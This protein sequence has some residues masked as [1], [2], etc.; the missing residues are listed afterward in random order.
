[1]NRTFPL[2]AAA[3]LFCGTPLLK[4]ADKPNILFIMSDDHTAQAIG[5]YATLLKGLN[6]TPTIDSLAE[7]GILFENAFVTNSIC[8]PS[9]ACIITGQYNHIN[10]VFDLGGNIPPEKQMLPIEMKKAGY[11]TAVIGKWHLKREPNFDYYKVLPGQGKYFDTEL[12]IQGEKP[13]PGNVEV[14]EGKHSSDVITDAALDWLRNERDPDKPFFLCHQYKAPHDYF[15]NAPRYQSYLADVEIPEPQTLYDVPDT[16]GSIGTRGHEDELTPHIG[17][18]IGSRNPRRS[19]AT[20]LFA[21][22]PEEYPEDYDPEKLS[23]VETTAISYQAYLKKYLRCVKGVDDNLK[24]LFDYLKEEG[25]YDKTLIIYTGDQGF[26]LGEKDFQDKRWAYDE[27]QRMPLIIRYPQAI[28]AGIRTDAIIENVDF[29]A[30]MLDY[31]GAAIPEGIQGKSFR[32]ICETGREPAN[33]KDAAYYRYWMH[34]AHH[35]NPGEMAMRTKEFKLIFF[36]GCNYEGGYQTPPGWELY[37]LRRDPHELNNVYD[38]PAYREVRD[39]LKAR[40]AQL[41]REIGDDGSHFPL[42]ER[43]VEEF[44]DY[45]A[46]DREKAIKLSGQFRK[47]REAEL[48]KAGNG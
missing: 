24:R 23:E 37:D 42:V 17:T 31:A 11:Q 18:S 6:P 47:N 14:H 12:R 15:E 41:R 22:F 38:L 9:R 44:W 35:D 19:Y 13:W 2:F 40:F 46:V 1:M 5:A 43:V 10:G 20:H 3:V 26:W 48:K 45:D 30:L 32:Q 16:W 7:E 4:A 27:S 25:L 8:T 36:Y 29:P 21:K 28:P 33:W 34:M 39:K